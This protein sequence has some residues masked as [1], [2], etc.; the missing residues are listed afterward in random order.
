MKYACAFLITI[1]STEILACSTLLG[2]WQSSRELSNEHNISI[3]NLERKQLQF[4]DQVF[5]H[6]K[7]TYTETTA[8]QHGQPPIKISLNEKEFDF[9]FEEVSNK[10]DVLECT[11][12]KAVLLFINPGNE[13]TE[14]TLYF[15]NSETYWV[16]PTV[17][18]K[19]REY[20][21][22]DSQSGT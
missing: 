14:V 16:S 19:V 11:K 7:V 6:M 17:T 8:I 4:F 9:K 18:P 5:G 20:F 10:Y 12:E 3:A 13:D 1:F 22:R 15:D 2:T 21:I